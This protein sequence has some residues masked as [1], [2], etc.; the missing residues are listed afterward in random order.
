MRG[1]MIAL[2]GQYAKLMKRIEELVA[3][4]DCARASKSFSK[5]IPGALPLLWHFFN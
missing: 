4:K 3:E 2:Q 5:E 1:L